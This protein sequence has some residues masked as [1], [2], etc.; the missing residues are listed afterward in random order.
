M[1][2]PLTRVGHTLRSPGRRA[3]AMIVCAVAAPA[4]AAPLFED[5]TDSLPAPH[6]YDGGW[7][8]YVGGGV[9]VLDCD[10]DRYPDLF[11]AGGS[12]PA[13]LLRNT[14][15]AGGLGFEDAALADLRGVAGAWPLDVDGDGLLDLAVLRV[16][17]NLLLRGR[18]DCR[19]EDA[20]ADWGFEPGADWSTAFAA[21]WEPGALRP[22]LAVGSY[23]DRDDPAG[24][25]GTCG[26]NWLHRP[27]GGRYGPALR[28]DPGHCALS[29][30]ISD[31]DR[32]GAPSLRIS[33]DR[34]YYVR[35]GAEQMWDVRPGAPHL[36]TAADGWPVLRLWGM[37]IASRDITG[38]G[39]PEVMLTSMGDQMLMLAGPDGGWTPAPFA[40]GAAAQRPHTGGDGR[41]ST[42]WH[43][44]FGDV[45]LDGY[46]DLFIAKGNVDQMP[47]MASRDPDNLL[48]R[49]PDGT[50]A[51]AAAAAG[52]AG[53]A[54]GRG[55]AL[56]DLDLDGRLD[57]VVVNRRAPMRVHRNVTPRTGGY[58][59]IALAAPAPNTQAV[60]AWIELRLPSGRVLSR[61]VTVGGGHGGGQAGYH[62]FGL[63]DAAAVAVRVVAPGAAPTDWMAVKRDA[64][65]VIELRDGVALLRGDP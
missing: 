3:I 33:N 19:F 25:F 20:T 16:G 4:A 17:P 27:D 65:V 43:A 42:G 21:L 40:M 62:H 64:R 44:A 10:G 53:M 48:M 57:L 6:V 30:L 14:T 49:Q 55:A 5:I 56:V 36:R 60:G 61:E 38:D 41:P 26:P 13:R 12:A 50:F 58:A 29:M 37:G 51:E 18:G 1:K 15:A 8:H 59:L 39:R 45:D 23:V 28:L 52:V 11:V 47:D 9:A 54:R 22:T 7:E 34:H 63:G 35:G 32:D 24:P 2:E 46:D 31:H